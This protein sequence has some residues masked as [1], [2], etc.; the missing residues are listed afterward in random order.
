MHW[1]MDLRHRLTV[2]NFTIATSWAGISDARWPKAIG[3]WCGKAINWMIG[4]IVVERPPHHTESAWSLIEKTI[5][6]SSMQQFWLPDCQVRRE[7]TGECL[8]LVV[9]SVAYGEC[10]HSLEGNVTVGQTRQAVR[11]TRYGQHRMSDL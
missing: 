7:C 1:A 8:K 5:V 2:C 10:Q 4:K 3:S 9:A 6:G 11:A